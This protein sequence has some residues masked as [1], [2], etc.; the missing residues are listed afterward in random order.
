LCGSKSGREKIPNTEFTKRR[1][2]E[3]TD[4]SIEK[5]D[6]AM[7]SKSSA[8]VGKGYFGSV[9]FSTQVLKTLCKRG[10]EAKLTCRSSTA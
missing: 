4:K 7:R 6:G 3:D 5:L 1:N 8:E 2:T 10:V 9:K